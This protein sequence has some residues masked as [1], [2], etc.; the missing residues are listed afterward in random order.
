MCP[1]LKVLR[2]GLVMGTIRK[3][4]LPGVS[5]PARPRSQRKLLGPEASGLHSAPAFRLPFN[6]A[7]SHCVSFAKKNKRK[8]RTYFQVIDILCNSSAGY[9]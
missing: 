6:L 2:A 5:L 8:K 7:C 4:W 9:Q 1:V 3:P